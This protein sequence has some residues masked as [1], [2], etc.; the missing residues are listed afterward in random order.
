MKHKSDAHEGLSLL[1]Q[2][3]GVPPEIIVDGSKE[4]TMGEFRKKAKQMGAHVAQMEPRSPWQNAAEGAI[5]ETKRSSGRK[6][7]KSG[8]PA[9]LWDHCLE[10]EGYI[11]SHTALDIYELEGQVPETIASGQTADISPFVEC[12]W[13]EWVFWWDSQAQSP[14]PREVLG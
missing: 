8:A 9:K 6:M 5:R 11:R 13:C 1:A 12:A 3:D 10:S 14:E 2:R 4:Q 7:T